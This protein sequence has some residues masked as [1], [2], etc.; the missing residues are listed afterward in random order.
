M[1]SILSKT[2]GAAAS[3]RPGGSYRRG[4]VAV[5]CLSLAAALLT[6]CS[7]SSPTKSAGSSTS[8]PAVNLTIASNSS[9]QL[10]LPVMISDFKVKYPNAN[11][12]ATYIPSA[13]YAS[14]IGSQFAN[15]TAADIVSVSPGSASV[16]AVATLGGAG[17]L[18]NLSNQPWADKIPSAYQQ[19]MGVNGKIYLPALATRSINAIYNTTTLKKYG[20]KI[21]T[22]WNDVLKLCSA[23]SAKGIAAYSIG[24]ATDYESQMITYMLTATLVPDTKKFLADRTSGTTTFTNSAWLTVFKKEQQMLQ[25]GCFAKDPNGTTINAAQGE[26]ANGQALAYFGQSNQYPTM[27]QLAPNQSFLATSLPATN[28]PKDTELSVAIE[29]SYG[30]NA[31]TTG[32][33][34]LV[35]ERFLAFMMEPAENQK[36]ATALGDTPAMADPG[37]VT[38]PGVKALAE[39]TQ[40]GKTSLVADQFFPNPNVRTVWITTS[41]EMWA[42]QATPKDITTAMD[43]AWDTGNQ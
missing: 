30:I 29:S 33:K 26:V 6:A 31:K 13:T 12:T 22:T 7:S 20:L 32:A 40:D 17:Y 23:A 37:F 16:Q 38:T 36:L 21:P 41:Q 3:G 9:Y 43:K 4:V 27:T 8:D 2:V 10:A 19:A 35:A 5:I 14:L 25:K 15:G 18:K 1:R 28:N 11:I 42:G 34:L 39:A 24:A